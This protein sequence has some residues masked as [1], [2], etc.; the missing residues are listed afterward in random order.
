[1]TVEPSGRYSGT[2]A[3]TGGQPT[4][5]LILGDT[6][7]RTRARMRYA[8]AAWA[9]LHG[10]R[11]QDRGPV[12]V[13]VAHGAPREGAD[14]VL[15]TGYRPRP[16]DE[17]AP[18]PVW[19]DGL[20]CFHLAPDGRPDVLGEI[21]EWLGASQESACP[22]VDDVGR[23]PPEH[24]LAG[25]HGLDRT[26]PWANRWIAVLH[27]A[28]RAALPGLPVAPPSPFGPGLTFVA[29]HDLDH[30][31]TNR[32]AN[33]RRVLK[34][35]GIALAGRRDV[36]T[37]AQIVGSAGCRAVRGAPTVVGV[38]D[39]LAGEAARGVRATYTVVAEST[40]R[41]DPG[42][43]LDDDSVRRTLRRIADGGHELAVHGSYDSLRC[44]GQLV[45]E[46]GLLA[47]AGY[48][49]T[50][51]RQH[52]LRHRG[53]ELFD[54]L[55]DAGA[56][57]DSTSGHPDV[58]GFRHGAAFPFLAYD[59][60]HE[61][62]RPIVEIPMVVMERALCAT[63]G[64]PRSW[65]DTATGVMHAAGRD[66]WGGTAIL[67]HDYACTGTTLPARLVQTY[68]D[69]LDAGD[70][71]VTAGELAAAARA[72]WAAAGALATVDA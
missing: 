68:W 46:Y 13:S 15:G 8:F 43:R 26:V 18:A 5:R 17:P 19:V 31:S 36:R 53:G 29:T 48:P 49:A 42:Y 66:G 61:R 47:A 60:A 20:P 71:W 45:R 28:V 9:A 41:R 21:F 44:P 33:G 63:A 32:L 1:M 70:R 54:A 67:W 7:A 38:D 58:V 72:R 56:Q 14:V 65:L 10:V 34:N 69:V 25:R 64:G 59:L 2:P 11:V 62:P 22:A 27:A 3:T 37:A 40:H 6:D 23:V 4:A 52:W 50:G 55:E 35:V 30:L 51:G 24:T 12:D 39:L 16:P 57:W